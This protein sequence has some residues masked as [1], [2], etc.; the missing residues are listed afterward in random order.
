MCNSAGRCGGSASAA[1]AS[2]AFLTHSCRTF[3]KPPPLQLLHQLRAA[4]TLRTN[5]ATSKSATIDSFPSRPPHSSATMAETEIKWSAAKVRQTFLEYF[6]QRGH[7]IGTELQ[8]HAIVRA[9]QL[10]TQDEH[11]TCSILTQ[12]APTCRLRVN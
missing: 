10:A 3:Y 5:I 11:G 2:Y 6:E 1:S 7:T 8:M 12:D 4:S 9:P